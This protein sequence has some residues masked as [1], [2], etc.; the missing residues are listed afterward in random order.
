MDFLNN[1]NYANFKLV[2][3]REVKE[4]SSMVH[5]FRHKR[6]GAQ[7]MYVENN[8]DNKVFSIAFKTVPTN[9]CGTPHILE[10]SVLNGSKKYPVKEPFMELVKG[11][12]QTFL[13]AMTGP[14]VTMYPFASTNDKDF[15]NLMDVYLDAVF[16][17]KIYEKEEIF[18]QEGWH[19]DINQPEDDLKVNGVVYNEMKGVYSSPDSYLNRLSRQSLFPKN[20]YGVDSGGTPEVIPELSYEEF[21]NFHK[22]FYHPS[23]SFIFVYGDVN[24]KGILKKLNKD[25][26]SLFK[27]AR[28]NN[29]IKPQKPFGK[30][31]N[32]VDYYPIS[33]NDKPAGKTY[34]SFN[35]C[36]G[37]IEDPVEKAALELLGMHLFATEGAPVKRAL[38]QAGLGKEVSGGIATAGKQPYLSVVVK[39]TFKSKKNEI[40]QLMED[41]YKK[42]ASEGLNKKA[43]EAIINS[44]EFRMRELGSYGYPEGLMAFYYMIDDWMSGDDPLT[45]IQFDSLF[46]ELREK[47]TGNYFEELIEKYFIGNNFRTIVT[48]NP[49][50][51]ISKERNDAFTAKLAA[52]KASLSDEEIAELIEKNKR[53]KAHQLRVDTPEELA[54]IPHIKLKDINPEPKN[55]DYE[56]TENNNFKLIN[57]KTA[58]NGISYAKLLFD[59]SIL[60]QEDWKWLGLLDQLTGR[61]DTENY[62]FSD[63]DNEININLGNLFTQVTSEKVRKSAGEDYISMQLGAKALNDKTDK[64]IELMEEFICNIKF[65]DKNRIKQVLQERLLRVANGLINGGHSTAMT[66]AGASLKKS[67]CFDDET[68]G[69]SFYKFLKD[70]V[71]NFDEKADKVI[72]KLIDI[73]EQIFRRD[74][75]KV[76]LATEEDK[77]VDLTNKINAFV[78]KLPQSNLERQPYTLRERTNVAIS[79]PINVQYATLNTDYSAN[80]IKYHGSLNVAEQAISTSYLYTNV[81]AQGGAY[82]CYNGISATDTMFIYSY[83]DPNLSRTYNCYSKIGEFLNTFQADDDEMT[84]QIIGTIAGIDR[85]KN[86]PSQML[87]VDTIEL[88]KLSFEDRKKTRKQLL[89]TKIKDLN[90]MG[91]KLQKAIDNGVKVTFGSVQ[92]I[93]EDKELFDVVEEF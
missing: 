24:I 43:I 29:K 17:P 60:K 79:A 34:F 74:G 20:T 80:G 15:L 82:G 25:Y 53:L 32:V 66:Y 85:P 75:L 38:L 56:I 40:V 10:H 86:I 37:T 90:A 18:L 46:N 2:W 41:T 49:S 67:S 83:R 48:L 69:Y 91:D 64:M 73:R 1:G 13:N 55:Y 76:I 77:V 54:V 59:A 93:E 70:V 45:S 33:E 19:Y 26:L 81:R 62:T 89:R 35:T 3:S 78:E 36:F 5:L 87:A 12:L 58:T 23:N 63:L 7:L 39:E 16:F 47:L 44:Q 21:T 52:V 6:N 50:K 28:I 65:D 72:A 22:T 68:N 84:K 31:K 8:D 61:L 4:I 27:K 30:V 9:S 42:I 11:S 71:N 14:D 92:K 51:T 57:L 88:N